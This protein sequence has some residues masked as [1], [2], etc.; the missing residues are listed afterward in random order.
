MGEKLSNAPVFLTAA[1]VRHNPILALDSYAAALQEQFR[2]FGFSDYKARVQSEFELDVSNPAGLKVKTQESRQHSFLNRAG[3]ACFVLDS[4]RLYFQVTDY[5]VFETFRDQFLRGLDVLHSLVTLD[6]IDSV[7]MRLLDAIVPD[8]TEALSSYVVKELLGISEVL[9][10]PH[11]AIAHSATE[12]VIKTPEHRVVVRSLARLGKVAVPPDLNIEGMKIMPRF[13]V[14][15]G[16]HA[17]LDTD[18]VFENRMDFDQSEISNRLR[19][20]KDDLRTTFHAAVTKHA[21][22]RWS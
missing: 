14:V 4:S 13:S 5:D 2:K 9:D 10:Q 11:W 21:R 1:Q 7:S 16:V 22:D 3:N 12:T 18:C 19:L 17:L 20:L 8:S 15:D 6:Y